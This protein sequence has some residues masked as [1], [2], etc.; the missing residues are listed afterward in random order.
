M[1]MLKHFDFHPHFFFFCKRRAFQK[2]EGNII[3]LNSTVHGLFTDLLYL[4][5]LLLQTP[6]VSF[7][8]KKQ[9]GTIL[10]RLPNRDLKPV[11]DVKVTSGRLA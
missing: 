1:L 2:H 6:L 7:S 9:T 3:F 10:K 5:G 4:S 11:N 8:L